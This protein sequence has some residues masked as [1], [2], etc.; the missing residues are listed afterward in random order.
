MYIHRQLESKFLKLNKF[1]KAILVTGARQ[2]GKTTMLKHLTEADR[3]Y[4]SLDDTDN[5]ML[6]KEDPKLF[7]MRYKPPII[8]DEVQK[9]PE[10]FPYIKI[11][12][13]NSEEK[14]LFW[15][16]GS[17]QY[18]MMKNI[19]ESLA[20]RI[21]IMTLYPLSFNE[22][23]GVA[24]NSAIDFSL[25]NLLE[26]EKLAKPFDLDSVYSF[27]WKGGMPDVQSA[28]SEERDAYFSSYIDTYLMRDVRSAAGVTDELRFKKFIAACAVNVSEQL[29][30][31]NLAMVSEISNPTAKSWLST[32]E[33]LHII[34][35]LQ[36]YENNKFKRLAKMPK[37]YFTDTGLCSYLAKWLTKE[38]LMGGRDSGHYFENFVVSEL[39]KDFH[40]S[41][42]NYDLSYFRDSNSKEVDLFIEAAGTIHPLEIKLSASPDRREVK[43]YTMLDNNSIPRGN[44]G[45]IC[46]SP[47]VIPIDNKNNLIPVSI[48]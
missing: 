35:L 10:L 29:N 12:C 11:M 47:T 25:D 26:R 34:F 7:F 36:P 19:T 38:T 44:G 31:N 18:Q 22:I 41:S 21:G 30:L 24:F 14:G 4:V 2:V 43:K 27:I 33:R 48:L 8:I 42:V 13:D 6:A 45:I 5:L 28:D 40:Y 20:G 37:L 46:M 23:N 1:F 39:I 17:E 32:L 15:L 9:A 16:T 3:T